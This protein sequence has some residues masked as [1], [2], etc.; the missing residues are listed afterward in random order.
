MQFKGAVVSDD[1]CMFGASSLG[2]VSERACR[3]VEAGCDLLLICNSSEEETE[4]ALDALGALDSYPRPG[5]LESL[6]ASP[7]AV[8]DL[9]RSHYTQAKQQIDG[10]MCE[11]VITEYLAKRKTTETTV[12]PVGEK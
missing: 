1:L 5:I 11:P 9:E 10:L 8:H 6:R 3:A 2:S 12:P 4:H 7:A